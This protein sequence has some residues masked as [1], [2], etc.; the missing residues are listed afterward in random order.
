MPT[1]VAAG[2]PVT[3]TVTMYDPTDI[4]YFAIYLNLQGDEVS[5]LQS[6]TQVIW[7]SGQVR[8][9][10]PNGLIRNATVT[11]SVDPDD[12]TKKTVT[13][14]VSFSEGMGVTNMVV[15]TWNAGGQITT[16][17]IFDAL[18]VRAPEP[19]PAMVD[20]EPGAEQN[21]VDP[22]PTAILDAVDPEPAS[23]DSADR[24]L[25]AIRMWSGFEPESITDAQ[26]LASLGLDY[27]GVDI[28]SW[29]MTELGVLVS[30]G[31]VTVE[32]FKTALEYVLGNA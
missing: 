4:A 23:Q 11:I 30:N 13:L 15:R 29:V 5:H 17:Q 26:L 10:D 1:S 21:A 2:Q 22:E 19:E 32:Q 14:T 25:L 28:P 7:D 8:I 31:E 20:P 16:V 24:S 27:P 18:D 3:I 12:P 6:D 9:I